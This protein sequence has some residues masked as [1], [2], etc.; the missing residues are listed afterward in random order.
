MSIISIM[1]NVFGFIACLALIGFIG[2]QVVDAFRVLKYG[3]EDDDYPYEGY[4]E[5]ED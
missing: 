4:G 2:W 3:L 5:D 1:G